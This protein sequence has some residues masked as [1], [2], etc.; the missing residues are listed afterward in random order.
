M[1]SPSPSSFPYL[2][3][4]GTQRLGYIVFVLHILR[5][6]TLYYY[7]TFILLWCVYCTNYT[8]CTP[9]HINRFAGL[10]PP[11]PHLQRPSADY[12]RATTWRHF[13]NFSNFLRQQAFA[14]ASA[15]L[16]ACVLF[17]SDGEPVPVLQREEA[18]VHLGRAGGRLL[19]VP[20]PGPQHL[21]AGA[22]RLRPGPHRGGGEAPRPTLRSQ[23]DPG[24]G[25]RDPAPPCQGDPHPLLRLPAVQRQL[26]VC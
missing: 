3:P 9:H 23:R 4:T 24:A 10:Y 1:H 11:P 25:A 15:F 16:S 7:D 17:V 21:H 19:Q 12:L 26:L 20:G 18:Q 6:G 8:S 2:Y 22:A 5:G 14:L 13:S